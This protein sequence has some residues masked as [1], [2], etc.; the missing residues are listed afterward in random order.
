MS[1]RLETR[2][3]TNRRFPSSR[4]KEEPTLWG[5]SFKDWPLVSRRGRRRVL[6]LRNKRIEGVSDRRPVL[7][8]RR[9]WMR[10]TAALVV[11]GD[12]W[13]LTT[14]ELLF[15]NKWKIQKQKQKNHFL[16]VFS[17][18]MRGLDVCADKRTRRLTADRTAQ[19]CQYMWT[20]LPLVLGDR[21]VSRK[22]F[23]RNRSDASVQ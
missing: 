12:D 2:L 4:A 19:V 22:A 9:H 20:T 7:Q 18:I 23:S 13:F 11:D 3:L 1:V 16:I 21:T 14:D 10:G 15:E 17:L 6:T 5:H 8:K